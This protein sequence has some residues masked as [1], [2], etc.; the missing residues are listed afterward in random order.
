MEMRHGHERLRRAV[1]AEDV[2]RETGVGMELPI[3]LGRLGEFADS[4]N[5]V[6]GRLEPFRAARVRLKALKMPKFLVQFLLQSLSLPS[7]VLEILFREIFETNETNSLVIRRLYL[8][9]PPTQSS[10]NVP[11]SRLGGHPDLD[12]NKFQIAG[13]EKVH[14]TGTAPPCQS[15]WG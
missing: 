1:C 10:A 6:I 9:Q 11:R 5:E 3:R 12:C 14:N 15:C 2:R 8:R 13:T 7:R 4:M